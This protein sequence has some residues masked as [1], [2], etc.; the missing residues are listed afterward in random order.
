MLE[1]NAFVFY[2]QSNLELGSGFGSA[3]SVRGGPSI[4]KELEEFD[5]L[6]TGE[7]IA[8]SGGNLNA[9][10]IVHAVGPKFQEENMEAKLRTTI[11]SSLKCAEE[12]GVKSLAFPPMGTGFYGIPL[13]VC[14]KVMLETIIHHLT[15]GST[16]EKVSIVA[17]DSREY[18]P[19]RQT[20]D[21]LTQKETV[22]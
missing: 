21:A 20:L 5:P 12:K 17:L 15:E 1:V 6:E 9:S 2:A 4:K 11:L 16:L 14:A 22:A 13:T 19:F 3:I 10:F 18:Q 8:T 7:A